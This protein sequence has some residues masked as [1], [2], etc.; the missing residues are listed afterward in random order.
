[1]TETGRQPYLVYGILRTV[2]AASPVSFGAVLTSLILFVL[3]YTSV[4]SMGILY[5]NRLIEKGPQ[6]KA[7]S[8]DSDPD[9]SAGARP[10]AAAQRRSPQRSRL[11][12][13]ARWIR[14]PTYCR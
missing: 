12:G 8:P 13:V 7:I 1:M 5:I 10:L 14:W 4:F 11:Q 9:A 3:I 6:G 2:D